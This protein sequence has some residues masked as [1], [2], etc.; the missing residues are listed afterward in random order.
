MSAPPAPPAAPQ[1]QRP[2]AVVHSLINRRVCVWMEHDN[3]LRIDG[4]LVGFDQFMNMTLTDA[5]EVHQKSQNRLQVGR[6]L[7]KGDN[8]GLVHAM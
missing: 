3:D 6:I 1:L 7:L 2:L 5:T 8:V 4:V